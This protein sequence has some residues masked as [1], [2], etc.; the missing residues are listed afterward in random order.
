MVYTWVNGSDPLF[1]DGLKHVKEKQRKIES[2]IT[3]TTYFETCPYENC[4]P[5]HFFTTDGLLPTNIKSEL[6]RSQNPFLKKEL[7][8]VKDQVSQ[9][10]KY[11]SFSCT[12]C[13]GLIF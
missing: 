2:N 1:L 8:D 7:V 3:K 10:N 9:R 12:D 5:S 11:K 6:L 4:I 13:W